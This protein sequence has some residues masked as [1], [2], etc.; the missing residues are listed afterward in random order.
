MTAAVD[1]AAE[2]RIVAGVRG[3]ARLLGHG[4]LRLR[5]YGVDTLPRQGPVLLAGNHS[6]FLDGPLVFVV[7]PR[8]SAFLV[9]SEMFG[10]AWLRW[11]LGYLRQIPIR[12][13]RP[14]RAALRRGLEV[15][16][17]GG[18]LGVFPEGTRG[19]GGLEGVQ[20]GIGYLAVRARCPIVPVVC[21]G[22]AEA[23]PK[24]RRLPRW[25]AP[26]DVVF[27]SPFE[28]SVVGDPHARA[29][30]AAAAEQ[31]RLRL[32]EHLLRARELTGRAAP[33]AAGPAS[34]SVSGPEPGNGPVPSAP[35]GSADAPGRVGG[36]G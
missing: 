31:I 14:D 6:S 21:L 2:T 23:M 15:L 20:H 27:G 9:K 24:G 17:A 30:V 4:V 8:P 33:R 1:P 22:T 26:V 10:A 16:A 12:R 34:G 5:L 18:V 28:V 36:L 7:L 29:T 35:A 13:G 11:G 32:V 19:T 25:R 3:L